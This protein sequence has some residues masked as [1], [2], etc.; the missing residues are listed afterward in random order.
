MNTLLCQNNQRREQVR[1]HKTLNGLDYVE[2]GADQHTLTVYFL[3]KS[4]PE[5]EPA[6]LLI[7]GGRRIRD[8]RVEAVQIERPEMV[9][10]DDYMEIT[11]NK[12]GDFST[13]S[14]RVVD[15]QDK[16]GNWKPHPCFDSRYDRVEFSFKAD[17]PSDLDCRQE[18]VCLPGKRDEPEIN[19]LAKDYASFRQLMFDRLALSMPEWRERHVPD[20]NVALVELLAYVG[21]HLSYY[22]DAVATEAYLDTARQRISVRRHARLVD[23]PMHEGCNA[24]TW[25]C[26]E[27]DS[28][29]DF[30]LGAYFI[31]KLDQAPT[32]IRQDEL[33]QYAPADYEVFEPIQ[34]IKLHAG[35]HAIRFHDWGDKGCCLLKGSTSATLVGRL[36]IEEKAVPTVTALQQL[37]LTP[38]DTL[39][40]EEVLD[41]KTGKPSDAD[42]RHRHVVRLTKVFP[43][44]DPLEPELPLTEIEWAKE[45]ALPFPLC[46]SS[47]QVEAPCKIIN[48]ISIARGNLILVDHGK[49]IEEQLPPIPLTPILHPCDCLEGE[50]ESTPTAGRYQPTLQKMP[51]VFS[52]PLMEVLPT[53]NLLGQ[54][55]RSALPQITLT[56]TNSLTSEQWFVQ[57][58]LLASRGDDRHFV[59]EVDNDG[60]GRLRFGNDELGKQPAT[61]TTFQAT[62]RI[63]AGSHGNVGAKAIRHLVT[64][65]TAL[66]GGVL[67]VYNPLPACGGKAPESIKDTRL[68]A[69]HV[70]RQRQARAITPDDYAAIILRE[71]PYAVQRVAAR[72]HW[73]GCWFEVLLAV[74]PLGYDAAETGLLKKIQDR[75]HR[76]RR[77]GHDLIVQFA[78]Q[79]PLD[80]K[81]E[82]C[83]LP[84][85]LR[86]QVKAVLLDVFSNRNLPDGCL[87]FFHPDN[88]SFG[89]AIFLSKLVAA[90]QAVQGVESVNVVRL[91]RLYEL[92]NHELENGVLPLGPFEIARLDNERSLPENGRLDIEVRGGR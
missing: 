19:Y 90:A 4:P 44:Y 14:V 51:L 22:Q 8:I 46:I 72:L 62:Y 65:N 59:V 6:N 73:N 12:P 16:E 10:L 76:Y 64:R 36:A 23:Y 13:Y 86:G 80:I 40:F 27:T 31:T 30:P 55:E 89:E 35:Q 69:P 33:H 28:D 85:Y 41:P 32:V 56:D 38:G 50:A 57:P 77:I 83:V 42:S 9:E 70:F 3:G 37:H 34:P 68:L 48:D 17:C 81:L 20:L 88:L 79:V 39:I 75:L 92:P 84:G 66:S 29:I 1:A 49:T 25:V 87:G 63:G 53:T 5:L 45:D 24:R 18:T 47:Q 52:Q 74:D 2:I 71:F 54:D 15:G 26:V 91:Q 7:E 11:V 78:Q 58:D 61:G 60:R 67:D 21:D 43:G 82:I